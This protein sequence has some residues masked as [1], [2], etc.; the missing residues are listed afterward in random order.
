MFGKFNVLSDA[1]PCC[2]SDSLKPV[3]GNIGKLHD[4]AATRPI[5]VFVAA[6]SAE[7]CR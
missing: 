1:A 5:P 3:F 6:S 7:W 4:P 2:F